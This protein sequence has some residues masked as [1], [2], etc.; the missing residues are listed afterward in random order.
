MTNLDPIQQH[1]I[2]NYGLN[3]AGG[4]IGNRPESAQRA[5]DYEAHLKRMEWDD[6]YRY[7]MMQNE[8]ALQEAK[9]RGFEHL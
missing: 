9:G 2:E 7:R 5:K 3:N 8:Q 6:D 1:H 4:R